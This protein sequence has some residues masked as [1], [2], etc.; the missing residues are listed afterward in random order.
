[1][2]VLAIKFHQFRLEVSADA[3]KDQAQVVQYF[4]CEDMA[5]VFGHKDQMD[6]HH[7]DAMSTV[8]E[9]A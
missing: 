5:A 8:A 7:K 2:I 1:M 6:M 9:L 4:P 3:G